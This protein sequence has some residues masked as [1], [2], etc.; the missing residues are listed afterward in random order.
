MKDKF[1]I[2]NLFLFSKYVFL[3]NK[4]QLSKIGT[5]DIKVKLKE[6]PHQVRNKKNPD[7]MNR[8]LNSFGRRNLSILLYKERLLD[9]FLR[10][11]GLS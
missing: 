7:S 8:D 4:K 5:T 6:I 3:L 10:R 1:T 2:I 9:S 11:T